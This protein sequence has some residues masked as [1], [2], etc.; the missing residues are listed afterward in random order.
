MAGA[1]TI[2]IIFERTVSLFGLAP[3]V[4]AG[5]GGAVLGSVLGGVISWWLQSKNLQEQRA[6]RETATKERN[7]AIGYA[8]VLKLNQLR[9]GFTNIK[10]HIEDGNPSRFNKKGERPLQWWETLK[11]LSSLPD[12]IHFTI[13]E[14]V[15]VLGLGKLD[16]INRML[17]LDAAFLVTLGTLQKYSELRAKLQDHLANLVTSVDGNQVS[18]KLEGKDILIHMPK[19]IDTNSI[20]EHLAVSVPKYEESARKTL[21]SVLTEFRLHNIIPPVENN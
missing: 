13:D 9:D 4:W 11:P 6:V 3:E 14:Q 20:A 5:L 21:N 16:L 12:P 7:T 18:A 19:M 2:S 8:I 17:E 1:V 15:L 10:K